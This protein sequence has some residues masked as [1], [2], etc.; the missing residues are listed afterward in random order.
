VSNDC[1]SQDACQALAGGAS[2]LSLRVG[3]GRSAWL[4]G[5][6][7]TTAGDP[8]GDYSA[9][10]VELWGHFGGGITLLRRQ[11]LGVTL[12][13]GACL[14]C[15]WSGGWFVSYEVRIR[16]TSPA[17]VGAVDAPKT[18]WTLHSW[19]GDVAGNPPNGFTQ[20]R[21]RAVAVSTAAATL[22]AEANP[23]RRRALITLLANAAGD[24]VVVGESP[25]TVATDGM[26]IASVAAAGAAFT[27]AVPLELLSTAEIWGRGFSADP[28]VP[29]RIIEELELPHE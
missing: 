19:E 29:I 25:L 4:V 17:G 5:A 24:F 23:R 12:P 6:T 10:V 28:S 2:P 15:K 14:V 27:G 21:S 8:V 7:Q 9:C 3:G 16:N 1:Q 22:I 26:P 18:A 20:W 13:D 11:Q